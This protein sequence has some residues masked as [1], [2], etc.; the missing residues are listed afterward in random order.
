MNRPQEGI[1]HAGNSRLHGLERGKNGSALHPLGTQV[2]N[3][4]YLEE[5]KKRKGIAYSNQAGSLPPAELPRRDSKN[6]E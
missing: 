2:A 3:F 6:P 5:V 1:F 4:F